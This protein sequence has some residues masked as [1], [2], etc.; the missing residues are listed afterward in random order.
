MDKEITGPQQK[1]LDY[2][3]ANGGSAEAAVLKARGIDLRTANNLVKKRLLT[4][5]HGVFRLRDQKPAKAPATTEPAEERSAETVKEPAVVSAAEEPA[6]EVSVE[7][8]PPSKVT[9]KATAKATKKA[10][11]KAAKP[12]KVV[13]PRSCLCGCGAPS[14][15]RFLPGHD[16]RLH[17]LVLRIHRGKAGKDEL[18]TAPE[19]LDYLKTASWMTHEIAQSIE[20]SL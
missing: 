2:I 5:T 4:L 10:A 13:E 1:V 11:E 14:K 19:T 20:L 12:A 15:S 9:K 17:S 8:A 16:A 6:N 18:T 7:K 3:N